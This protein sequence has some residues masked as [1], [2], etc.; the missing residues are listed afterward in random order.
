MI[1]LKTKRIIAGLTSLVMLGSLAG[2]GA[3]TPD[4][5][6]TPVGNGDALTQPAGAGD[7]N[8][9]VPADLS[10][11]GNTASGEP[12]SSSTYEKPDFSELYGDD[13][14]Q[15]TVFSQLA[16]YSGKLTGWFAE[17]MKREFNVEMTIIPDTQ[18]TFDTRMEAGNLGDLVVFGS[19]GDDY[20]RAAKEGML[21]DWNED[22]ILT[23]YGPYIKANMPYALE[24][25]AKLN[26]SAGAGHNVYGFGH[27]V[28]SSTDDHEA[29][30]YTMDLRWDLYKEL[31]YPTISNLDGLYDLF[32]EMKKICPKDEN[33]NETYAISMWPDWDGNM[34]MYIKAFATCYWGY[35]E[36]GFGLYD[37]ETGEYHDT[38]ESD[39][40]YQKSLKF[41]NKLYQAGLIDPNS[42][43]QTYNEMSEKVQ[44]GGVFY[45]IFDYAGSQ[46]YNSEAHLTEGKGMYPIVPKDATPLCYGM[47]VLGGNRIWTI[48][49][50]TEYPELC[51]AI[52]NY[53]S[54]PEGYMTYWWGP[55]DLCWYY[56]DEGLTH[57]TELGELA[58]K[59]RKGT[60]MPD[61]WGGGSFNDGTFQAN[62]TTW[63]KDAPNPDSNGETY[64]CEN[65]ASRLVDTKFEIF[66]DWRDYSG[67][68]TMQMYMDSVPHKIAL[69]TSY[70]E[71]KRSDELKIIWE[72]VA[73]CIVNYSWQAVYASSDEEYDR[74]VA[75]MTQKCQEYDPNGECLAW[76]NNEAALRHALEE[77]MRR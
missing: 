33:G 28:A 51:M 6:D 10:D 14:I 62:N 1:F 65:W 40:P 56:D 4:D 13:T 71:S 70:T 22:D 2:C 60:M 77:E 50:N 35:D 12:E 5:L 49:A 32:L 46:L 57:F 45:S 75:E 11:D 36:M 29:F 53:L 63:S 52:I 41:F 19:N 20:Q 27:N 44:A 74:I 66:Q 31:G 76:C 72:Q 59:D 16:N 18:G 64:N 3:R 34:V 38:L 69:G 47:N 43:T 24:N 9:T 58:Y 17:V 73:K 21:F 42:M 67:Q 55:K 54:T 7:D 23:E 61:E 26:E 30:F 68:M 15:L 25:N 48:G 37:V 8:E 39:G